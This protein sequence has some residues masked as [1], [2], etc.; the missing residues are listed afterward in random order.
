MRILFFGRL[1]E[2]AGCNEMNVAPPADVRTV[3]ALRQWLA[4]TRPELR[5]HLDG[6]GVRVALDR[7]FCSGD[8][9]LAGA[10][11]IAFMS[12]LSGG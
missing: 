5:D 11:E 9:A 2:A 1:G 6:P 10:A 8:A 4:H 12:P 3:A 7:Q